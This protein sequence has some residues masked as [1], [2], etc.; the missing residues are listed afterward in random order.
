MRWSQRWGR[1]DSA[2]VC[3]A[4]V[5]CA[6]WLTQARTTAYCGQNCDTPPEYQC[7]VG[8]PRI[9]TKEW[10]NAGWDLGC[11]C[12]WFICFWED[13]LGPCYNNDEL[14]CGNEEPCL[15]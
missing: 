11:C 1:F 6:M 5:L 12:Y 7:P 2:L 8:G 15:R 3:L 9:Y 4:T 14:F 13:D 10:V